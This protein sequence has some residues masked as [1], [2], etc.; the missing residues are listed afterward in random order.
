MP[1][2]REAVE[3]AS[4]DAEEPSQSLLAE[5]QGLQVKE[6]LIRVGGNS[7]LYLKLLEDMGSEYLGTAEKITELLHN[8]EIET[9][10]QLAHKL[11]GIANN[12]GAI[13]VG[14]V[15]GEIESYLNE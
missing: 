6:G 4:A 3:I 13:E 5:V 15:S 14:R 8:N 11:R 10:T 7:R 9:A 2:E 12:L 1:G